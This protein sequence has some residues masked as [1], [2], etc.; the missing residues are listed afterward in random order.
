VKVTGTEAVTVT[1]ATALR[2][3]DASGLT[4]GALSISVADASLSSTVVGGAG[5]DTVTGSANADSISGGAGA[6]SLVGG[7]GADTLSGGN[8]ADTIVGGT[9]N[10]AITGGEGADVIVPGAGSDSITLTETTAASDT[11]W[12]GRSD[13]GGTDL[14]V[15]DA[16]LETITGFAAGATNGDVLSFDIGGVVV[17]NNALKIA[18]LSADGATLT[19]LANGAAAGDV[20][21]VIVLGEYGS[22]AAVQDRLNSTAG[23]ITDNANG[24]VVVWR[25]GSG[26][27][28]VY[29]DTNISIGAGTGTQ[30]A[31]LVG[32]NTANLVAA[33]FAG[34]A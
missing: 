27:T 32:V 12:F 26:D 4:A 8:A 30:L 5:G 33:N 7:A 10:D 23:A 3:V 13:T 6:D 18:T 28:Q 15:G 22:Y 19:S 1:T 11:V 14:A 29:F 34:V 16:G 25:D 20:D 9:G 21:V 17:T 31:V 24:A 2:N